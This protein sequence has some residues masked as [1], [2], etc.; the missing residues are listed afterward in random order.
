[1]IQLGRT[2]P[3]IPILCSHL[4]CGSLIQV[5]NLHLNIGCL[6]TLHTVE[7][8]MCASLINYKFGEVLQGTDAWLNDRTDKESAMISWV[9][10]VGFSFFVVHWQL[11]KAAH[12]TLSLCNRCE[13]Y[14]SCMSP[15]VVVRR[16]HHGVTGCELFVYT[17]LKRKLSVHGSVMLLEESA[18]CAC[19]LW[20]TSPVL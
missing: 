10:L 5:A 7:Q 15:T 17:T 13:S 14:S 6:W 2:P 11:E 19:F 8:H 18:N 9:F 16:Y 12:K 1:M 4:W 20:H 3:F